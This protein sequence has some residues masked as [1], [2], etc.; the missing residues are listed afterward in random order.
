MEWKLLF[1]RLHVDELHFNDE[2]MVSAV[3]YIQKKKNSMQLM[4]RRRQRY[5]SHCIH[6][7]LLCLSYAK[8]N[9]ARYALKQCTI[10]PLHVGF[11]LHILLACGCIFIPFSPRYLTH[12]QDKGL[13]CALA[14]FAG[15][16]MH[17]IMRRKIWVENNLLCLLL[18]CNALDMAFFSVVFAYTQIINKQFR[19]D[20]MQIIMLSWTANSCSFSRGVYR[21]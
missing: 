3:Q 15:F 18:Q 13:V 4:W 16:Q 7:F 2:R 21:C 5:A 17:F 19:C 20:I 9:K 8:F 14:Y 12:F 11:F 10:L 6:L 1:I